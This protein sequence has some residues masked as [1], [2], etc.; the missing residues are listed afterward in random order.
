MELS[1]CKMTSTDFEDDPELKASVILNS[2]NKK[3]QETRAY[4]DEVEPII[5]TDMDD[6]TN[7]SRHTNGV[8]NNNMDLEE[9]YEESEMEYRMSCRRAYTSNNHSETFRPMAILV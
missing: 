4:Y 3:R 8:A 2:V 5:D 7:A 9:F 6:Q 1:V